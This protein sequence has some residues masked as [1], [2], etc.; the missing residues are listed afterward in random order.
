[1]PQEGLTQRKPWQGLAL[2]HLTEICNGF[3]RVS[4]CQSLTVR[5]AQTVA[6]SPDTSAAGRATDAGRPSP[7]CRSPYA[8]VS[9]LKVDRGYPSNE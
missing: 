4:G 5:A 6:R 2:P 9:E 1:M 7:N 8:L 3:P